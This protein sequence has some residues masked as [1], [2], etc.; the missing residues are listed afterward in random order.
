MTLRARKA[1]QAQ[2]TPKHATPAST[3]ST[4]NDELVNPI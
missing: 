3:K 1:K 4:N 2:N